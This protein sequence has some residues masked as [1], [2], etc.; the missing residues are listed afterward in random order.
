[1]GGGGDRRSVAAAIR[2]AC[3]DVGFFYAV[4]HGVDPGLQARLQAQAQRFF[5]RPDREKAAIAM[6]RGGRAWRGWFP[7]GAELTSGRPDQKEGLYL[8]AELDA[9]HPLVRSHT[10]LHGANLFPDQPGFRETVLAWIDA[11]TALGHALMR[12]IALSL[13]LSEDWFAARYTG[14]P[15]VLFRIFRYPALDPARA[16]DWSVGEHTDYGVLT[17]LLQDDAGGLQVKVGDRWLD[18]P[19]LPASFV[20]NIGDMLDRMTGGAYRSTP[21][22]V[23]NAARR[24]RYSFPFFFDPGWTAAVRPIP[25]CEVAR[26]DADERWDKASVHAWSGTYG[27]YLLAKLSRVFPELGRQVL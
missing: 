25:G 14:D 3:R 21:H 10:P 13:D 23:R 1:V 5:A 2:R 20:C 6:A 17:I 22:R 12:G 4:G 11:M 7:V 9:S 24:D 19:P 26:D 27:D 18:A 8:G 16:D 15:L